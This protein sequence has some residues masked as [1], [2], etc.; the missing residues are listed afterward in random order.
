MKDFQDLTFQDDFM[1]CK[2]LQNMNICKHVLEL[3]LEEEL[4]VKNITSQKTIENHSESKLVRLD[5]LAEDEKKNKFNIEMQMVNNDKIPQRMRL[6]QASIDVYMTEKGTFYAD[7]PNT[8]IIFFC[9][10][11]PIG[12]RL[13]VYTF[14]NICEQDKNI[15]LNDGTAKIII[16]V[17]A[18]EKV[19]NLELKGL[20]KYICDG[21]V[22]NSLTE[23]IEMAMSNIKQN[24]TFLKEYKSFYATMQDA[25]MEGRMEGIYETAK[26][27]IGMNLSIEQIAQATGLSIEEIAKL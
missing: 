2:V 7:M 13:P 1:F 6:Y 20:M 15:K 21:I 24:T 25:K 22:T 3:V 16:N 11:D 26:N 12:E 23:E 5:V 10:F 18:Y 19:K 9:M 14:K 8:V 4:S 17:K 27:L